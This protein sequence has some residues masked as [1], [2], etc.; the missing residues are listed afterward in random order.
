MNS[1]MLKLFRHLSICKSFPARS[2][3]L[4]SSRYFE[5]DAAPPDIHAENVV[6]SSRPPLPIIT[7]RNLEYP[8]KHL[9]PRQAWVTNMDTVQEEKLGLVDLHP[10]VF[11]AMPR[12]DVIFHNYLWQKKYRHV[13]FVTEYSR[14]EMRGGG[15]KPWPQKGTGRA[16]H[17][18]IRSPIFLR[19]GKAHGK[20]G[21]KTSFYML[22]L[23]SR[24]SGL[25]SMLSSKFAQ[26]DLVIVD[27]LEIPSS[28]SKYIEDLIKERKWG[29][30]VLLINEYDVMPHNITL[31]TDSL[32]SVTL[33]PF[34][35]LNVWSMLKYD[36]LVLTVSS[37]DK[38]EERLLFQLHRSDIHCHK[39]KQFKQ[40]QS[41]LIN[42]GPVKKT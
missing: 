14:A 30:S 5:S 32:P 15:R 22:P 28:D 2:S 27:S 16:R 36:T 18:S 17:G 1:A 9:T 24:V 23:S 11:S 20:R 33:M 4:C 39:F 40:N 10:S 31:A 7:S 19:G 42:S 41:V 21:P 13:D 25:I 35:G 3:P 6:P 29:V 12:I 37:L 38:I 8:K 26:D 34:Y